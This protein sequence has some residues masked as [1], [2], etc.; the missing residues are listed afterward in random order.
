MFAMTI[1][2]ETAP[3]SP[4]DSHTARPHTVPNR[5]P[6]PDGYLLTLDEV[7]GQI[8]SLSRLKWRWYKIAVKLMNIAVRLM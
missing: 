4:K 5:A 8:H 6:G 7:S 1:D 3:A 2:V